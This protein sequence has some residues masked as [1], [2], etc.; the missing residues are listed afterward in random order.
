MIDITSASF[1][2]SFGGGAFI[3]AFIVEVVKTVL[4]KITGKELETVWK[5]LIAL[6]FS[7]VVAYI[8]YKYSNSGV[9][10]NWDIIPAN[11]LLY[12]GTSGIWYNL[13]L[14]KFGE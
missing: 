3:T 9:P 12:W 7:F 5:T 10:A 1:W 14:K 4:F 11:A 8:F 2:I 13:I 6:P